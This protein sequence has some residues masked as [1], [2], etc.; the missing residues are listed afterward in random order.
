MSDQRIPGPD[1]TDPPFAGSR[2]CDAAPFPRGGS[3]LPGP[4]GVDRPIPLDIR[5]TVKDVIKDWD[6]ARPKDTKDI[7][8]S[9]KSLAE[10][11]KALNK[12]PE[13]GQG[14]GALQNDAIPPGNTTEVT[15]TLHGN[16][17]LRLPKWKEYDKASVAAK[18]EWD[19]MIKKLRAHEQRHVDIAVEEAEKLAKALI[20]C[21]I[22]EVAQMV[23]DA[24][25]ALKGRQ[26]QLDADTE[27]G[28]K[29]GVPYGD[30]EL[31]TSIE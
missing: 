3:A 6:A 27:S 28:S 30:V 19:R 5:R 15:V 20:G 16:L 11:A 31:D 21:E 14:G 18:A 22:N 1:G 13:W 9:G 25:K 4:G 29:P 8:V 26:D 24:N 7:P 23:T 2:G 10:V 17:R 12:L